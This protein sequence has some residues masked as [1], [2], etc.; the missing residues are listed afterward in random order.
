MN[1][2]NV[3]KISFSTIIFVGATLWACVDMGWEPYLTAISALAAIIY[4]LYE[5]RLNPPSMAHPV[6]YSSNK[7]PNNIGL[8]EKHNGQAKLSEESIQNTLRELRTSFLMTTNVVE[9]QRILHRVLEIKA[10]SSD[11]VILYEL[12]NKAI[13]FH[14]GK[15]VVNLIVVIL[16]SAITMSMLMLLRDIMILIMK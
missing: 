4:L 12:V 11:A 2:S 7:N 14:E 15:K 5:M 13:R 3:V 8:N 10:Y 9:L 1:A 16:L 6:S